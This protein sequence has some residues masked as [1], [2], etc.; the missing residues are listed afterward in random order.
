MGRAAYE[1][2]PSND[3]TAGPIL[4]NVV[5]RWIARWI[6]GSIDAGARV[7]RRVAFVDRRRR[8]GFDAS[9]DLV[10]NVG[11]D[12]HRL[13]Q[14]LPAPFALDDLLV[15]LARRQIAI[16]SEDDVEE[17]LVVPEVQI[18]LPAV[19]QHEA[20]PVLQRRHRPGVDLGRLD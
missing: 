15:D 4:E 17:S 11:D 5:D 3:A 13:P 12:L 8:D 1:R 14:V 16:G 7:G 20:F 18:R 9:Q 19:V 10:R 2:R 6:D